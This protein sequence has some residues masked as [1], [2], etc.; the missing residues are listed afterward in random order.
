MTYNFG[1]IIHKLLSITN[2]KHTR[3]ANFLGYDLTYISKWISGNKLP[4]EKNIVD[5]SD[6]ICD[7]FIDDIDTNTLRLMC[8]EFDLNQISKEEIKKELSS[9]IY[10]CFKNDK[11]HRAKDSILNNNNACMII[12]NQSID[13]WVFENLRQHCKKSKE[14][15]IRIIITH[16]IQM[17]SSKKSVTEISQNKDIVFNNK[18]VHID[19]LINLNRMKRNIN[20]YCKII[21]LY[22]NSNSNI[23]YNLYANNNESADLILVENCL[24]SLSMNDKNCN[25]GINVV[26]R[27]VNTVNNLYK[28]YKNYV[29]NQVQ[30]YEIKSFRELIEQKY[31]INFVMQDDLKLIFRNMHSIGIPENILSSLKNNNQVPSYSLDILFSMMNICIKN[32]K[33]KIII[34]KSALLNYIFDG[35]IN[36]YDT[37]IVLSKED[38]IEHLRNIISML[39]SNNEFEIKFIEDVNEFISISDLDNSLFI[40]NQSCFTLK[41]NLNS[42]LYFKFLNKELINNFNSFF[43]N[44]WDNIQLSNNIEIINFIEKGINLLSNE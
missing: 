18:T 20:D 8:Y 4:S 41:D 25:L 38:R 43:D 33:L 14:K 27:D 11:I 35:T 22:L 3:L 10:D 34:Y 36:I 24:S 42:S 13:K 2:E 37:T 30:L 26:S 15:N 40:S 21:L 44:I 31:L 32:I 29:N 28:S 12:N 23:I 19:Q 5:I 9:Y 6:K 17:Y 39:K 7:F 1:E 16:D